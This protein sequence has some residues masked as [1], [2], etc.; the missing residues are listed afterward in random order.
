MIHLIHQFYSAKAILF[1]NFF[2]RF[3]ANQSLTTTVTD[4]KHINKVTRNFLRYFK[5][6]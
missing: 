4:R 5:K 2:T 1:Y 6:K 3:T